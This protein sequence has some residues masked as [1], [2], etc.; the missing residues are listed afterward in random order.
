M[1]VNVSVGL[2]LSHQP[3]LHSVTLSQNTILLHGY[4]AHVINTRQKYEWV[5]ALIKGQLKYLKSFINAPEKEFR[6]L[7]NTANKTKVETSRLE[8]ISK[9]TSTKNSYEELGSLSY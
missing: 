1:V 8:V 5:S 3:L 6:M 7:I 2:L 9:V 4:K